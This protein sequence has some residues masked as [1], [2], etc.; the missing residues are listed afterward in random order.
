VDPDPHIPHCFWLAGSGFR[1]AKMTKKHKV[2][3]C[4]GTVPNGIVLNS[5]AD[6]DPNPPVHMFL[7]FQDQDPLVSG[8]DPDPDTDT[9]RIGSG[10]FYHSAKVGRK[11]LIS[12]VL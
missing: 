4:A 3:K 9:D 10:S 1:R 7:G 11:T 2:K 8:M 12:T 6:P 5:N